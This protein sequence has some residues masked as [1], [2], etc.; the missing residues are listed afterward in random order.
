V[1]AVSLLGL[2]IAAIGALACIVMRSGGPALFVAVSLAIVA[3]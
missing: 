2:L 1:G 3:G